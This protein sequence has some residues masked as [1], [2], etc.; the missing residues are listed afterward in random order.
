MIKRSIITGSIFAALAIMLGAFGAHALELHVE[1]GEMTLHDMEVYETGARYQFYHALTLILLGILAKVFGETKLLRGAY[2][3]FTVGVIMFSGS[4]YFLSTD[5]I[6][7]MNF[8][9]LGPVTPLGGLLLITAWILVVIS[10]I[11]NKLN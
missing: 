5:G 10:F 1:R 9:W 6:T 3:L 4:L 11:R 2:T 7:G 8:S